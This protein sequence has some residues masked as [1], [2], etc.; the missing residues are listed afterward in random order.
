MELGDRIA[1]RRQELGM[2]QRQLSKA[3]G[4]SQPTISAI[5]SST[6]SPSTVT[7]SLI[8]KAL[9]MTLAELLDEE[10]EAATLNGDSPRNEAISL[11]DS[12]SEPSQDKALSYLRFLSK[13]EDKK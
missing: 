12:L 5:E 4:V 6:K 9:N 2:S 10:K 13:S 11:Y 8:A 7:V 1:S 3:C